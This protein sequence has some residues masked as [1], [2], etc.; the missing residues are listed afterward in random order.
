M[1]EPQ[2]TAAANYLRRAG[3]G[4]PWKENHMLLMR[5][6]GMSEDEAAAAYERDLAEYPYLQ[7]PLD[8]IAASG[9]GEG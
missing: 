6:L 9:E 5:E 1:T 2:R 3:A 8:P 4:V 7:Q